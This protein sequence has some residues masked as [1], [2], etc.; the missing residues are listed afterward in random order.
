[1]PGSFQHVIP[2][3]HIAQFADDEGGV[4]I[5]G[6]PKNPPRRDVPNRVSAEHHFYSAMISDGTWDNAIDEWITGIEDR[7]HPAYRK[8]LETGTFANEDDY[9]HFL[10]Y[11]GLLA[12]RTRPVREEAG[13][14][15]GTALLNKVR[16]IAEGDAQFEASIARF[17]KG[18]GRK[19]TD[20]EKEQIRQGSLTPPGTLSVT[21]EVTFPAL[22]AV[23]PVVKVLETMNWCLLK[24][25]AGTF[26]V[27]SD[28]PVS[29]ATPPLQEDE[30]GLDHPELEVALPLSTRHMI[31]FTHKEVVQ[32]AV[33]DEQLVSNLNH[34]TA[35]N[36]V[37][38][39][40]AHV[41][42]EYVRGLNS[43]RHD[44]RQKQVRGQ[45]PRTVQVVRKL[46]SRPRKR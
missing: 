1:M 46:T 9:V 16:T 41:D 26:F 14:L 36:E 27:T 19:L 29:R 4:F 2:A 24:A 8:L 6:D 31:L 23:K 43:L 35:M 12:A 44:E 7:G 10:I 39:L 5:Y 17:E 37:G 21:K 28:N 13:Q 40:Y 33:A 20:A 11:V 15:F 22:L 38:Y 32:H 34:R 42:H 25:E 18:T 3:F 45:S 30:L